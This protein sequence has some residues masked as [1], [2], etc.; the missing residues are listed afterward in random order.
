MGGRLITKLNEIRY[1]LR[2]N[3]ADNKRFRER[4]L[5]HLWKLFLCMFSILY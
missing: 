2:Y 1:F 4:F 5:T 3:S